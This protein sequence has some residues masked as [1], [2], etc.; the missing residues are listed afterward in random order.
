MTR[1]RRVGPFGLI[2]LS[3]ARITHT[4]LLMS[5]ACRSWLEA[6]IGCKRTCG[7]DHR[8]CLKTGGCAT[9]GGHTEPFGYQFIGGYTIMGSASVSLFRIRISRD[10]GVRFPMTIRTQL[11]VLMNVE[12]VVVVVNMCAS[13]V[14]YISVHPRLCAPRTST[15]D[16]NTGSRDK[17]TSS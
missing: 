10:P 2:P 15:N 3:C 9:S 8:I 4:S 14:P 6:G 13:L 1:W 7:S 16:R 12:T 5:H 11:P 17:W